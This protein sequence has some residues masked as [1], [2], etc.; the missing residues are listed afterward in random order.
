VV[1]FRYAESSR[2]NWVTN[3]AMHADPA[4]RKDWS[5]IMT[6]K[7]IGLIIKSLKGNFKLVSISNPSVSPLSANKKC[8][9]MVYP[10]TISVYHKLRNRP[11]GSPAPTSV[12]LDC[13][14]LSHHQRRIAARMEEDIAIYDY[15][16]GGKTEMPGFMQAM[17]EK[18]SDLQE[19]ETGR[20]RT[21]I[22]ELIGEVEK[23]EKETWDREDAVE[24]MGTS[25]KS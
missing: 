20:A 23:L 15:R 16:K 22:W 13:M 25:S 2:V 12:F 10:D 18:T 4:H 8:K 11:S 19:Q 3:F 17:F 24:D 14:I 7:S 1:Y 6:P 21:R 9:P 5:E